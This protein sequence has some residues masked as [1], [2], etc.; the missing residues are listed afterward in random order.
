MAVT[1]T[2]QLSALTNWNEVDGYNEQFSQTEVQATRIFDVDWSTRKTFVD[3]VL[4][5]TV[6]S[7]KKL[8]RTIPAQHPEF[9]WLYAVNCDLQNGIGAIG[10]SGL[11][12]APAM[13]AYYDAGNQAGG[14]I[15]GDADGVG[16][17]NP[18][19]ES[20]TQ[21]DGNEVTTVMNDGLARYKV[22][23]KAVPWQVKTDANVGVADWRE[24]YRYI[25]RETVYSLQSLPTPIGLLQWIGG[26]SASLSGGTKLFPTRELTY[27]WHEV[28]D[29]PEEAWSECEGKVNDRVF[30]PFFQY[31]IGTVLCLAPQ[32]KWQR[33][34][35]GEVSWTI[36]YKFLY[37]PQGHNYFPRVSSNQLVFNLAT[38]DG[39]APTAAA[40]AAAGSLDAAV[41]AAGKTLYRYANFDKLFMPPA[42]IKYDNL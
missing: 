8:E 22:T 40:I 2:D 29:I 39:V 7:N 33:D 13:I 35:K 34:V 41:A 10:I 25:E 38:Y 4:G 17:S 21:P 15:A 26:G 20:V 19:T 24:L 12:N 14:I 31:G 16:G 18:I 30:D 32:R 36:T 11:P 42:H 23:Y 28:P 5:F 6:N 1:Y 3:A 37:R 27:I 9:P